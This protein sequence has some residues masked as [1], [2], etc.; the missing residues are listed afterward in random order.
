MAI[1][2]E[3]P[4]PALISAIRGGDSSASAEESRSRT[5]YG[6]GP[7]S[8]FSRAEYGAAISESR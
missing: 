3:K 1:S 8:S 5:E 7:E 2:D 4:R 6:K